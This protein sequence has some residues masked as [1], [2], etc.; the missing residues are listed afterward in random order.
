MQRRSPYCDLEACLFWTTKVMIN[1]P[2]SSRSYSP[3]CTVEVVYKRVIAREYTSGLNH[4][5]LWF[6][7]VVWNCWREEC[8][9]CF[10]V[11]I[12]AYCMWFCL[13]AFGV[14]PKL[15]D[16]IWNRQPGSPKLRDG[17]KSW[18][19]VTVCTSWLAL[20][21]GL[22]TI[23]LLIVSDHK[24]GWWEVLGVRLLCSIFQCTVF[25]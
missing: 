2:N 21:P 13:V 18:V 10:V 4:D 15:R 9:E 25:V 19:L 23:Q 3:S 12:G 11:P 20:F 1:F 24:T 5:P 8:V 6:V 7:F 16:K 17:W 22:P 14:P